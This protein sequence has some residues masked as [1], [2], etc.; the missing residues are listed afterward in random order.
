MTGDTLPNAVRKISTNHRLD[1][2][3]ESQLQIFKLSN[4]SS[5]CWGLSLLNMY[6]TYC[7]LG[8]IVFNLGLYL[9]FALKPIVMILENLLTINIRGKSCLHYYMF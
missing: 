8:G 7:G 5:Q 1:L 3:I 9:T 4:S 2:H 6:M